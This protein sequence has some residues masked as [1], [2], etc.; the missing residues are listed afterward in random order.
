MSW[1]WWLL[2]TDND[3]VFLVQLLSDVYDD[4]ASGNISINIEGRTVAIAGDG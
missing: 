1:C 4:D 2:G 3:D